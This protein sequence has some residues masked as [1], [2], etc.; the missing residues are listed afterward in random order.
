MNHQ[1]NRDDEQKQNFEQEDN[2]IGNRHQ[3]MRREIESRV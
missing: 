1:N 3:Q 2:E